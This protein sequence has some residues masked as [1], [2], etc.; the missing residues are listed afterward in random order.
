MRTEEEKKEPD[1]YAKKN[2]TEGGQK[3]EQ[4]KIEDKDEEE[5]EEEE[6]VKGKGTRKDAEEGTAEQ[7]TT[8]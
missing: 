5:Q 3:T 2:G 7:I 8:C 1:K 6:E 4:E